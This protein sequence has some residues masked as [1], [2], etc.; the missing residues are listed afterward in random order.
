LQYVSL[1]KR[2]GQFDTS[3]SE[4][5]EESVSWN[6]VLQAFLGFWWCFN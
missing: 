2:D 4:N 5:S 1:A 6:L 3:V